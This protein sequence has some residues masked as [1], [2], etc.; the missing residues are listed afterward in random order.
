LIAR[1]TIWLPAG[2]PWNYWQT[3]LPQGGLPYGE[4]SAMVEACVSA[5]SQTVA[6]CPGDHW[7][8]L[9]NGGRERVTGSALT[10]I[11]RQP[12]DYQSIS[13][14]L[15]NLT[16]RLYE[17][18][19][20]FA[21]AIRNNR[22]EIAEL[23][24]LDPAQELRMAVIAGLRRCFLT[25]TISVVPTGGYGDVDLTYSAHWITDPLQ[26]LSVEYGYQ[27]PMYSQPFQVRLHQGHVMLTTPAYGGVWVTAVQS[28]SPADD[29]DLKPGDEVITTP[30]TFVASANAI[31]YTGAAPRFSWRGSCRPGWSWPCSCRTR[32]STAPS[33]SSGSSS[34]S[35][36]SRGAP[37]GPWE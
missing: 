6:M 28:G 2:S 37:P 34:A 36:R 16:R 18:G 21:V 30:M 8:K 32:S 35:C 4:R 23:H 14:F 19:E 22:G 5:Y 11:L 24:H 26:V 29:L 7:R 33:S 10:R 9:A 31:L 27:R 15:L 3:G 12:N 13:D 25:D 1:S 20:A 17:R